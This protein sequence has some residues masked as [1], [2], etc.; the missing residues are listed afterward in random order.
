MKKIK[1]S[2]GTEVTMREPKVKDMRL[3]NGIADELDREVAMLVNLCEMSED[4]ID[5]LSGKDFKKLD[6]ALQDFLS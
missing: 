2:N 5:N 6:K 3:V 4:E 1:L